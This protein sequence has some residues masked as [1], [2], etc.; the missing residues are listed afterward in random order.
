[1]GSRSV[2]TGTSI[3]APTTRVHDGPIGPFTM[4]RSARSPSTDPGVHDRPILAFTIDR[5]PHHRRPRV[6]VDAGAAQE[7]A[8]PL[9]AVP[10]RADREVPED[11]RLAALPD[12]QG[13]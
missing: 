4:A 11:L 12:G 8:R 1:M 13:P 6:R 5:N 9:H 2:A 10:A 7:P 3:E